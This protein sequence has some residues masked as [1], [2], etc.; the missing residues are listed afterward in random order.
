MTTDIRLTQSAV[1]QCAGALCREG[2]QLRGAYQVLRG[3]IAAAPVVNTGDTIW[4]TGSVPSCLMGL[5]TGTLAIYQIRPQHRHEE[6][7]EMPGESFAGLPGTGR[8]GSYSAHGP[9]VIA[10]KVSQCSK[11]GKGAQIYESMKSVVTTLALRGAP[12]AAELA[13]LIR[14][15]TLPECR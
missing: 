5:F 11:N 3:E 12:I 9:A 2:G 4:R 7:R 13:A 10:R 8:G 6:V 14:R 1:T 15:P